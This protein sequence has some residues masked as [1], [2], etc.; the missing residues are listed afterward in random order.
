MD[1]SR[2]EISPHLYMVRAVRVLLM[3]AGDLAEEVCEALEAG[4]ATVRFLSDADAPPASSAS[5]TSSARWPGAHQE[6]AHGP[7]HLR[8]VE[9]YPSATRPLTAA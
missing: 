2:A 5:H 6:H 9:G 3:G 1:A 7:D 8:I 4:G